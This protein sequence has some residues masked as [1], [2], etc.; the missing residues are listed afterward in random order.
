[1]GHRWKRLKAVS[2]TKPGDQYT[3]P[4]AVTVAEPAA[5]KQEAKGTAAI[6]GGGVNSVTLDSG[7]NFYATPPAIEIS[8]P[9]N[10]NQ[11]ATAEAVISNGEVVGVNITDPGTG[12]SSPPTV[13]IAKST[14]PK[15]DFTAKVN[16]EFDS[17]TGTVTKVKVVDSGN[18][19][20]SDNPPVVTIDPPFKSTSFEIGE[21]VTIAAN[22][23]GAVDAIVD[24][25]ATP[26]PS[27]VPTA[28]PTQDVEIRQC[29]TTSPTY[30]VRISGTSGYINSQAIEIT[31]AAAGPNPEFTGSTCWEIIDDAATFYDSTVTVNSAYS[32]CGG[33]APTPIYEYNEY[34]ECHT[35]T[36]QVFRKL[37]T[38]SSWPSVVKYNV[39][40][41]DLCFSNPQ[42]TTGNSSISVESL[43]SFNTCF[44][45]GMFESDLLDVNT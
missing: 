22:S 6:S 1:M 9:G 14:D 20:D 37:T 3:K 33:C 4:P 34:T 32:S 11:R 40:G 25:M 2:V 30:K 13:T 42:S 5:P 28:A 43:T 10:G 17:A 35:N 24:C 15:S 23:T 8:S 19:Y 45:C 36:T 38:T 27:P 44:D 7:G 39:S 41:N 12:Y 31:G 18:F 21:D 26:T 29:G 16:L